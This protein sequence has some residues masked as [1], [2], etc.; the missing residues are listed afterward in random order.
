MDGSKVSIELAVCLDGW[1]KQAYR[2][3]CVVDGSKNLMSLNVLG[4]DGWKCYEFMCVLDGPIKSYKCQGL[5]WMVQ[6]FQ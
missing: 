3:S 5:G 6:R 1:F 2:V 4:M